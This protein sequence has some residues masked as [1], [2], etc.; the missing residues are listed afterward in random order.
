MGIFN[1]RFEIN[2]LIYYIMFQD[3]NVELNFNFKNEV[4]EMEGIRGVEL[5][6]VNG[7]YIDYNRRKLKVADKRDFFHNKGDRVSRRVK[8]RE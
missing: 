5:V 2:S 8:M 1:S 7:D 4:K 3:K 6:N